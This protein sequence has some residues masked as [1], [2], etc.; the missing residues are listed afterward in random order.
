M[1]LNKIFLCIPTFRKCVDF[2]RIWFNHVFSS[3]LGSTISNILRRRVRDFP[4]D[5]W[6]RIHLL[7]QG[8]QVQS[9][10]QEDST[11]LGAAKSMCHNY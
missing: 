1:F 9:L 11:F 2:S 5:Q 6:I 7:M 10:V 3:L 4:G 8:T